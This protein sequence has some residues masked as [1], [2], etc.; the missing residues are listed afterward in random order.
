M[1][2]GSWSERD[3]RVSLS[4]DLKAMGL[5]GGVRVYAP[6]VPGLQ[7]FA[8]VDPASVLVPA[9]QGVFLRVERRT[10]VA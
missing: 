4:M 5:A 1:A 9:N 3:E 6:A 10:P 7:E 2:I 8:E